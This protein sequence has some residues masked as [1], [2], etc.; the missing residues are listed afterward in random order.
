MSIEWVLGTR[1]SKKYLYFFLSRTLEP[2]VYRMKASG[3]LH[4]KSKLI[5]YNSCD[6][7][8]VWSLFYI[9]YNSCC[10]EQCFMGEMI[11]QRRRQPL[12]PCIHLVQNEKKAHII[13]E[14]M[15]LLWKSTSKSSS[16][17][18]SNVWRG[19]S[20][21]NFIYTHRLIKQHRKRLQKNLSFPYWSPT[22]NRH[23]P[24]NPWGTLPNSLIYLT[25][26]TY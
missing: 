11:V 24:N 9:R 26:I 5:R 1:T 17:W 7:L 21:V 2:N 3:K 12:F 6:F 25:F 20:S 23:F 4:E 19:Y 10:M 18:L 16:C 8:C 14:D 13:L 15:K 22:W